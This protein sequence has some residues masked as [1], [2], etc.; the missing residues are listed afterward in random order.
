MRRLG[1]LLIM[2]ELHGRYDI[3]RNMKGTFT[4]CHA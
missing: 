3:I 2:Y 4:S 1:D